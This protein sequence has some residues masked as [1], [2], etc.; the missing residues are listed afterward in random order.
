MIQESLAEA[1]ALLRDHP[2]LWIA[3]LIAGI[4][5]SGSLLLESLYGTFYAGKFA[6]LLVFIILFFVT[7]ELAAIHTGE[8]SFGQYLK[9]GAAKYFRVLVPSLVITFIILVLLHLLV[10]TLAAAGLMGQLAVIA[11]AALVIT[12]IILF[13]TFFYD[14][15]AVFEDKRTFEAIRRSMELVTREA[16]KVLG[17]YIVS[18]LITAI[19][20]FIGLMAWTSLLFDKLEP[21]TTMNVTEV[22][23]MTPDTFVSL[24]G[25]DG[26]FLTAVVYFL[27]VFVSALILLPFKAC[28][29]RKL[30][31]L[32]PVVQEVTGEYDSKGRWYKY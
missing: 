7:A 3:G 26:I 15:A 22:S 11:F 21:L 27:I 31:S 24:L 17:F 5:T 2:V 30:A 13:L 4:C 19:I 20:A 14:T 9:N 23:A 10:T 1:L 18:I 29:Y 6:F 32:A 8:Y 12:V 28:F 25:T 16:G